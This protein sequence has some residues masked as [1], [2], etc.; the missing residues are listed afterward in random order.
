MRPD[1]L[2]RLYPERWRRRYGDELAAILETE[3]PSTRLLIDIVR[4]ALLAHVS[5]YP[6]GGPAMA[7][8]SRF[9]AV[10][11]LLALAAVIPASIVIAAA[12]VASLQPDAY[13]PSR[14]AHQ[15]VGWIGTLPPPAVAILLL[16]APGVA[17]AVG[18]AVLWRR[19]RTDEALRADLALLGAVSVRLVR[20]PT[21][22]VAA[23]AVV[24]AAG[25]LV[26]VVDH[27][28]VG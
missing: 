27:L 26:L 23:V 14:T 2:I 1:R 13:E 25:V 22:V 24:A 19:I 6:P 21:V 11:A 16:G 9:E 20:R 4:G 8:R 10:G 7:S 17:L 12:I 28:I 15:V 3:R 18:A 5:P